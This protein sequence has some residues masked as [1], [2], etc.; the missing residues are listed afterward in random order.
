M[1]IYQR[2]NEAKKKIAYVQKDKDVSTGGGSYRAVTHDQVTAHTRQI[3]MDV[4]IAVIPTE[5]ECRVEDT[6]SVTAKGAKFIRFEAKYRIAFVNVDTPAEQICLDITSHAID[7]GD[8]AP[9][10]A[11]SYATKYALLKVLQLETGD[12]DESRMAPEA[13][14]VDVEKYATAIGAAADLEHLQ[15][16]WKAI[17]EDCNKTGDTDAYKSLKKAVNTRKTALEVKA[18]A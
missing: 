6:G 7:N 11:L 15:G 17:A 5:L 18:P 3:L 4:G 1:N 16:I 2:L 10:K 12:D 8:K 14:P 13:V 9:G